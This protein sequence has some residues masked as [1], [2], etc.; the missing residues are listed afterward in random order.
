[1]THA[2]NWAATHRRPVGSGVPD[3]TKSEDYPSRDSNVM[4]WAWEF[5]RRNKAYRKA[6]EQVEAREKADEEVMAEFG[7]CSLQPAWQSEPPCFQSGK[8]ICGG[9]VETTT[10]IRLAPNELCLF[11]DL[12]L[13]LDAQFKSALERAKI[14]QEGRL[15]SGHLEYKTTRLRHPEIYIR[16]LRILDVIEFRNQKNN[17]IKLNHIASVLYPNISND[18][19][20][21]S[22]AYAKFKEDREVAENL[23]DSG[24]RDLIAMAAD[25]G[26]GK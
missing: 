2:S 6:I 1:M 19:A 26:R 22:K 11:F 7:L 9:T 14:I 18:Y 24:Y 4:T 21:G 25:P 16:Y 23:R 12:E 13:P 5:L 20:D 15:K 10:E 17:K 3:W 8:G